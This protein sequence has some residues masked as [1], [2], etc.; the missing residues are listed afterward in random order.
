MKTP[1]KYKVAGVMSGTSLDGLD[2]AVC[3]YR[4]TRGRWSFNLV[5]G[6][7]K[8]YSKVWLR[9]LSSAHTLS[10]EQL[11]ELDYEFGR[12]I[13]KSCKEF[14]A[15]HRLN[16]PDFISSHGHT[17]FHQPRKKFT[18]QIGNLNAIHKETG[19]PV[20]ADFRSL[21]VQL[22]GEGA[23]LVPVG[24]KYLFAD[25][26]VCLNIGGIA[27]LSVDIGQDRK[28]FDVC[29]ANM[30]LN[31]L[32]AK[33]GKP[34]DD[35]GKMAAEGSINKQL[36]TSLTNY[37]R[38]VREKRPSLGREIFEKSIQSKLDN[39]SIALKDRLATCCES[40]AVEVAAAMP[41]KK[42]QMK[43]LATGGGTFNKHLINL[44]QQKLNGRA[45]VVVPRKDIVKYKE[46]I[47][48]GFLGV[49]RANRE[50]NILRSVTG[51][52]RDS[53]SGV[54]IGF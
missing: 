10:G 42:H 5:R 32:T 41:Q 53:S 24:D 19:L 28:A 46:A 31:Y 25:Y 3:E 22:G 16:K 13:G 21:D 48:F 29:F 49:L 39:E 50:N 12:F 34:F 51:A 43:I 6:T 30:C 52:V 45:E 40:I 35:N 37:Y 15:A 8:K 47:V 2:I 36:L 23:P 26:D 1:T 7:T 4:F 11:A 44:L 38:S 14:F 17:V 54:M 20:I 27:N 9:K 18:Y 33:V